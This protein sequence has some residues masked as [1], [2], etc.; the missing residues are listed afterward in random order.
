[1]QSRG[2]LHSNSATGYWPQLLSSARRTHLPS[3]DLHFHPKIRLAVGS[4]AGW[5]PGPKA[6]LD[7]SPRCSSEE[8]LDRLFKKSVVTEAEVTAA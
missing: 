2:Y 6:F 8:L 1:M 7:L 5:V 4:R 3:M